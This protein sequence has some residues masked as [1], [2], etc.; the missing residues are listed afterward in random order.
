MNKQ[1]EG[2]SMEQKEAFMEKK[3]AAARAYQA[4]KDEARKTINEWLSTKPRIEENVKQAILYLSGTG[5]RIAG[6]RVGN[7]LKEALLAG[8]MTPVEIFTKFEYGTPTMKQKIRE[9]IK[10]APED[11]V[12]VELK[13]GKYQ[14]VG[15]GA[16]PPKDWTGYLPAESEEL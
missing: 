11:R 8:P 5:Q 14:V 6:P 1:T 2:M 16:K 15:K 12:W 4:R 3:R 7:A 9:M 13:D 10:V